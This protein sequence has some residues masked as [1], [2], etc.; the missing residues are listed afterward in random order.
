MDF[1]RPRPISQH[2]R[3]TQGDF[4]ASGDHGSSEKQR[5]AI[6]LIRCSGMVNESI[7]PVSTTTP[8]SSFVILHPSSFRNGKHGFAHRIDQDSFLFCIRFPVNDGCGKNSEALHFFA[9]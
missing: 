8:S 4:S 1:D 6:F 2:A 9:P 5:T 7:G 3:I